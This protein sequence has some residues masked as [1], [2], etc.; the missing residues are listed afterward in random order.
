VAVA[1]GRK[2][3]RFSALPAPGDAPSRRARP[4]IV[5]RSTCAAAEWQLTKT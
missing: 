4:A 3:L 2:A 5:L 1:K